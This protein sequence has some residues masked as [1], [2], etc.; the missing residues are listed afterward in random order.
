M[1]SGHERDTRIHT[2][3]LI[4]LAVVGNLVPGLLFLY[5]LFHDYSSS[6][7]AALSNRVALAFLLDLIISTFL[8]AYLFARKPLG[9]VKWP[10][11]VVLTFLGTLA[12]AI[13]LF[14]WLNWRCLPAPRPRF[15]DWWRTV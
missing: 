8:I 15:A 2:T 10:W 13:P 9:P 5:G 7:V 12:F 1:T 6:L 3:C 14:L 4:L 11:F